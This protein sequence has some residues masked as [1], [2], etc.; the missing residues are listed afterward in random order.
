[1]QQRPAAPDGNCKS[2]IVAGAR[3]AVHSRGCVRSSLL[4]EHNRN[5]FKLL[6]R[7]GST[8][9]TVTVTR[10]S[11]GPS[12]CRPPAGRIA[13]CPG[14]PAARSLGAPGPHQS[15]LNHFDGVSVLADSH[16]CVA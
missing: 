4:V 12:Q 8:G 10:P 14:R 7:L 9:S 2:S 3:A 16:C 15:Q 11:H 13:Q 5:L 1:M 6:R